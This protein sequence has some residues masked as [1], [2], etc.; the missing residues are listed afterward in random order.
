MLAYYR[1]AMGIALVYDVTDERS[2]QNIH[3]WYKNIEQHANEGVSKVLIGNKN[4]IADKRVVTYEEGKKLA[5]HYGLQFF[6]AS[7][8]SS[9]NVESVFG[10]LASEVKAR[11]DE[12]SVKKTASALNMSESS[13]KAAVRVHSSEAAKSARCCLIS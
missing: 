7:A 9:H 6:E 2:F 3:T 8:K 5:D 11:I 1:T 4:D 10:T 13:G 12:T